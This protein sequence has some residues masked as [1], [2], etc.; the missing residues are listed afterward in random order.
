MLHNALEQIENAKENVNETY[1]AVQWLI[2]PPNAGAQIWSLIGEL[3]AAGELRS[4]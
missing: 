3:A 4:F 1:L 2:L